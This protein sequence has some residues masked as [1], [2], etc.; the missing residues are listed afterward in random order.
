MLVEEFDE[1]TKLNVWIDGSAILYASLFGASKTFDDNNKVLKPAKET[2]QDDL[3][4]LTIYPEYVRLLE[5][6]LADNI[7][8]IINRCT[9]LAIAE[10]GFVSTTEFFF[11]LDSVR[12][13]NWRYRYFKDY[14]M[15]RQTALKQFKV[16]KSF[17]YL[18][19][20]IMPKMNFD[21]YFNMT[22]MVL[23]GVEGDD[24]IG[25]SCM[26]RPTEKHLII[27]S[28]HDYLQLMSDTIV[29]FDVG[30]NQI[31]YKPSKFGLDTLTTRQ[32]LLCKIL[33]GDTSD[34]IPSVFNRCG[35]KTAGKLVKDTTI[36]KEKLTDDQVAT[37]QFKL[38]TKLMDFNHIPKDKKEEIISYVNATKE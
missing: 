4:D 19:G 9:P 32:F 18:V 13:S 14:K 15:Q 38:N 24:I 20:I 22:T 3:L 10:L 30:A 29:Q 11:V 37:R 33:T 34:N 36:L 8:R 28:D 26:E 16:G 17:D 31:E 23:E 2:D 7:N 35:P 25:V 5:S 6:K 1:S 27:A 21:E 12:E